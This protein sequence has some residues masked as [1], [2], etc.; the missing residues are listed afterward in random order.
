MTVYVLNVCDWGLADRYRQWFSEAGS[1]YIWVLPTDTADMLGDFDATEIDLA[2][3]G[4]DSFV[5]RHLSACAKRSEHEYVGLAVSEMSSDPDD[6]DSL[7]WRAEEL[8]VDIVYQ[9]PKVKPPEDS[10]LSYPSCW[11]VEDAWEFWN[12]ERE[13]SHLP[14]TRIHWSPLRDD[15]SR[16]IA[17]GRAH[18]NR[19]MNRDQCLADI[20]RCLTDATL[21]PGPFLLEL[22]ALKDDFTEQQ[23]KALSA[24]LAELFA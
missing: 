5:A 16:I 23:T 3:K 8:D 13:S 17:A 20:A 14:W 1:N 7:E 19:P 2:G 22:L 18:A 9:V 10:S 21:L 6:E 24:K 12:A 4:F 15:L 11:T